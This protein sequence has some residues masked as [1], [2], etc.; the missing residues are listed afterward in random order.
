MTL[1]E[2]YFDLTF[3]L[4]TLQIITKEEKNNAMVVFNR[5]CKEGLIEKYGN[6]RGCYIPIQRLEES[7]IDLRV[8]DTSTLILKFPFGIHELVK[9]MPKNVIVV[10]GESNAGKSAFLLNFAAK[11]MIDHKVTY[12]S[13]EMGSAELKERLMNFTEKLPFKSWEH[14]TF[15]ERANDFDLAIRPEGINIIDFLE[16]HDDFYKVGG[17]IKKIFDKLTTGIAVI[18]IQ[19]NKGRDE[20]LGGARSLEKARLYI[21]MKPGQVKIV[22]A[23]NWVSSMIN[24]NNLVKNFKLAKGMIFTDISGWEHEDDEVKL[25]RNVQFQKRSVY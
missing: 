2:G 10:A 16:I 7:I 1:Q 25:E 14:C 15:I 5:L 21:S 11:N 24:P 6:K 18:A 13:S 23:K 19:K 4:Q 9:I 8:A 3:A 20:G 22:K 17:F 12:F